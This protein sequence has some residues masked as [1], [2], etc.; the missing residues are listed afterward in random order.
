[1]IRSLPLLLL[2]SCPSKDPDLRWSGER[3]V[4][5]IIAQ[6]DNNGDGVLQA[7]EYGQAAYSAPPFSRLDQ[8]NRGGLSPSEVLQSLK[9]QDPDQRDHQP[10]HDSLG[11][12]G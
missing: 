9:E 4:A 10:D 5:G 2:F 11:S 7:E 3:A 1:M 12:Q 8:D 6:L